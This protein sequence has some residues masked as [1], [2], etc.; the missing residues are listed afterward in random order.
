MAGELRVGTSGYH[1]K[2]W[3]GTVYPEGLPPAEFLTYY[4]RMFDCVEVNTSF[5]RVPDPA[6]FEGMLERVPERFLFVV[7]APKEMTHAPERFD[8][9]LPSFLKGIAP[10]READRFGVVLAQFPYAFRPTRSSIAHLEKLAASLVGDGVPVNVEF[11]HDG[12]IRDETFSTL[13]TLG[14]GFVNVDLPRLSHLPKPSATVTSPVGYVR[15]HGRNAEMWWNHPTGSHRYDYSYREDE[16]RGW[17]DRVEDLRPQV[18]VVF[19][20]TNNCRM[21]ASIVDAL[22]MKRLLNLDDLMPSSPSSGGL[23]E[24]EPDDQ[25]EAMQQRVDR[26]RERDRPNVE[27]WRTE[28]ENRS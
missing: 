10:L 19:V 12:W 28:R 20:F 18:D 16:L 15:L 27:R 17:A 4:A 2:D 3:V 21:G 6:L 25:V 1:F 22:R 24:V 11:R 7:K 13:R 5:Y 8:E 9:V 23:F 26:A 14:L